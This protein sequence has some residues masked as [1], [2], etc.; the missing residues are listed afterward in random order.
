MAGGGGG[1]ARVRESDEARDVVH[2]GPH[3]LS[4][5]SVGGNGQQRVEQ[6]E[7]VVGV[8]FLQTQLFDREEASRHVQQVDPAHHT[9]PRVFGLAKPEVLDLLQARPARN[10]RRAV[11]FSRMS[12]C[13][14]AHAH[15]ALGS[16]SSASGPVAL[17]V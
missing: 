9:G 5:L 8:A 3:G 1:G 10:G 16:I 13:A 11:E 15:L 7:E 6:L 12:T 2:V 4:R 17:S 14:V